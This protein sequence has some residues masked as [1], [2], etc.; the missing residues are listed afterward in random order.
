MVRVAGTIRMPTTLTHALVG[1][2]IALMATSRPLGV[3]FWLLSISLAELPDADV[4]SFRLGIP[5][6]SR[7]GHRGFFHSLFFAVL[8]GLTIGWALTD[9]FDVDWLWLATYAAIQ[10]AVH[11]LL[12][13]CTNGGYGIA[14]LAPFRADRIFFPW[15]PIQVAPIG[16]MALTRH[17]WPALRSE[18]RWVWLPLVILVLLVRGVHGITIPNG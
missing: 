9:W 2:G 12:D 7:F 18:I 8:V 13:A 10:V 4:L 1:A 6:G 16:L 3:S 15:R 11:D 17:G 14:L 5:Y